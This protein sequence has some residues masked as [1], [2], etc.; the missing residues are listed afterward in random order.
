[1]SQANPYFRRFSRR[2]VLKVFGICML[3]S[4]VAAAIAFPLRQDA[5]TPGKPDLSAISLPDC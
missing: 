3:L 4:T 5:T 2:Y 1:M